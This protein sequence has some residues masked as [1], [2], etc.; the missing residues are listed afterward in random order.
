LTPIPPQTAGWPAETLADSPTQTAVAGF[1][2]S[3][4]TAW[5]PVVRD[6]LFEQVKTVLAAIGLLTLVVQVL[7]VAG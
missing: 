4:G 3:S 1:A 5:Q 6:N 2:P 7:R